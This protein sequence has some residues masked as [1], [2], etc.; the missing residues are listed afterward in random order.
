MCSC[1]FLVFLIS[2]QGIAQQDIEEITKLIFEK[3]N[4]LR[5]AKGL[6]PYKALDSLNQLAQYHS[7]N[8]VAKNFYSHI[9]PDGL[10]PVTRQRN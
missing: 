7:D 2:F 3:T 9:D 5:V 10:T 8:M 1:L 4:R 6:K